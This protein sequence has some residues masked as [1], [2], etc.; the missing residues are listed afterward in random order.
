MTQP[1]KRK[2]LTKYIT[3]ETMLELVMYGQ[4]HIK[5]KPV[6]L[7][8]NNLNYKTAKNLS[9]RRGDAKVNSVDLI[10]IHRILEV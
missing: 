9:L 2:I 4:N 6:R 10:T 1:E 3:D 7:V 5:C 8:G